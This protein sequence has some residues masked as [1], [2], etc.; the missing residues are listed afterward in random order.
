M[1]QAAAFA[2][3]QYRQTIIVN[4]MNLHG[5]VASFFTLLDE[6]VTRR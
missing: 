4:A 6:K 3:M 5:R 2:G 1:S